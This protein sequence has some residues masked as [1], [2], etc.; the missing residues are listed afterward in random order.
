VRDDRLR[1]IRERGIT[2][3]LDVGA[4]AGQWATRLREDG[5]VDKIISFEPL[6]EAYEHLRAAA[7]GDPV[8]DTH[9]T[10][11]GDVTGMATIN[12]SSNSYSSSF[13]PVAQ[14]SL[15]AA[16]ETAYIG[17]EEVAITRLDGLDLPFGRTMLKA[18]VQGTEPAVIRGAQGLLPSVE[19]VELEMSLVP[20]Y[21]GQELA[22][23]V[24]AMMRAAGFAPVALEAS[25]VDPRTGEILCVDAIFASRRDALSLPA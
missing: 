20:I 10:A 16:P 3:V 15:D 12:V 11:L 9:R 22:P 6:R 19:L 5:Y 8:W 2:V 1:L 4:N 17:R 24:C 13:L 23:A 25:W 21:E 18:D 14:A 7:D